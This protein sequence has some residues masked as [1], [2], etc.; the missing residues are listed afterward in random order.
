[1]LGKVL[2]KTSGLL[3]GLAII[4]LYEVA[5]MNEWLPRML[6]PTIQTLVGM[7]PKYA[8]QL[9]GDT[10]SSFSLLIPGMLWSLALGIGLGVPIGLN[11]KI[12][13]TLSP[14]LNAISPIPATLLTPYAVHLISNLRTAAI[15]VIAFA[16]FWPILDATINGVMTINKSY[17]DKAET[18]ELTFF[19]KLIH[20]V[21]PAIS[22]SIFAGSMTAL[23]TAFI[24]VTVAEMYGVS[25]GLGFF[26]QHYAL[27]GSFNQTALGFVVMS[28][29]LLAVI[30]LFELLKRKVLHW[31]L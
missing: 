16:S 29:V 20:V 12:R 30:R 17:L 7:V 26:V 24:L 22:P 28:I 23:R 11:K 31:A 6:F 25:S 2:N 3:F 5:T 18:L 19:E 13:N 10:I 14:T 27:M 9:F 8:G 1:M 4:A 21:L 15:F